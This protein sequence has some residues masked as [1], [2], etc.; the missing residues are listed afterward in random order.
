MKFSKEFLRNLDD[1][2]I[3]DQIIENTRWSIL[4]ERIFKHD[5]K[6]YQT[7]YSVGATEIQDESPYEYD[8]DE[9]ECTEVRPV[10]KVVTVYEPVQ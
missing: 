4:H 10:E 2:I 9:I 7:I 1:E 6:F 5:G 3:S 8:G